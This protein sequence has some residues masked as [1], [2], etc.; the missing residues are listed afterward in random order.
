MVFTCSIASPIIT[1]GFF[2]N[3]H[4]GKH[5]LIFTFTYVYLPFSHYPLLSTPPTTLS[6]PPL[7]LPSP[8]HPSHYPLLSTPPTTL[9][10]P[11]F[12]LPSPPHPSHYPLLPITVPFIPALTL[13]PMVAC[14]HS[15]TRIAHAI[16][17]IMS[18]YAVQMTAPTSPPAGLA[19]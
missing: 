16:P 19:A 9:S 18:Q 7:S 8:L 13:S 1:I 11:P 2:V 5:D 10:S 6:S 17:P 12:P 14:C 4:P 3:L 15:V